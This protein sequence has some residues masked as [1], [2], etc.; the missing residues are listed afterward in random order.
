MPDYTPDEDNL[1][2]DR[3][4]AYLKH[5]DGSARP[6]EIAEAVDA[7]I[8]TVYGELSDLHDGGEVE[9]HYGQQVIAHPMPDGGSTVLPTD[10]DRLLEIIEKWN[11]SLLSQAK[12]M[13]AP[14]IRTLIE[15]EIAVGEPHPMGNRKTSYSHAGE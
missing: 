2:R 11:P 13:S 10:K 4:V 8:S 6:R 5:I 3:I 14:N 12:G 1:V 9:K 7:H 15:S